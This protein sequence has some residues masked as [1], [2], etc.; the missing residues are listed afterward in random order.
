MVALAQPVQQATP[1][2]S[3]PGKISTPETV[4]YAIFAQERAN[5]IK[6]ERELAF[7][8]NTIRIA[9]TKMSPVEKLATIVSH[10]LL[11]YEKT[12]ADGMVQVP[13]ATIA[14]RIG[15]DD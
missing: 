3:S 2:Q 13:F 4:P 15:M 11:P 12:R 10:T 7:V 9:N 5:R 14:E 1:L 6:A 8:Y